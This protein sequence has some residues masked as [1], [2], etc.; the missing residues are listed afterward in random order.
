[1]LI[2]STAASLVPA[3][4]RAAASSSDRGDTQTVEN[5]SSESPAEA[6][7]RE[8]YAAGTR[9]F[10]IKFSDADAD[11]RQREQT[12]EK[13]LSNTGRI[14]TLFDQ[15]P[16]AIVS[17]FTLEGVDNALSR[18]GPDGYSIHA[19]LTLRTALSESLTFINQPAVVAAGGS[20]SGSVVAILDTG[21][22]Y[23]LAAFGSCSAPG[24]SCVVLDSVEIAQDDHQLDD[25][26]D[27]IFGHGTNVSAI[28]AGVAP[29]TQL[30]V[31]DVFNGTTASTVDLLTAVNQIVGRKA[32]G[33]NVVAVN[34]SLGISAYAP[35]ACPPDTIGMSSLVG[36]GI[37]PVVASGNMSLSGATSWPGCLTDVVQVGNIDDATAAIAASGNRSSDLE[38]VAPGVSIT[39]GGWTKTGTSMSSPHVAGAVAIL[40]SHRKG[41]SVE[42]TR[43]ALLA[44]TT[45]VADGS[46]TYPVLD[47]QASFDAIE[48]VAIPSVFDGA[49][50]SFFE[51]DAPSINS[52][53][54]GDIPVRA[55]Y[56]GDGDADIAVWRPSTGTWYIR[57]ASNVTYGAAGDIPIPADYDGDGDAD[58]AVAR[59]SGGVTTWYINGGSTVTFGAQTDIP[60]PADYDGDGDADIAVWRPST[61][62][63]YVRGE[64]PLLHWARERCSGDVRPGY[65]RPNT[66]ELAPPSRGLRTG[67][68]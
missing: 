60:V 20:G 50:G 46:A 52:G 19:P 66:P 9:E 65:L 26:S 42:A 62:T 2:M 11:I 31:F 37:V 21:V 61:G 64:D 18:R 67:T 63:W 30:V 34:I 48:D 5:T 53:T 36:A 39:A 3:T 32:A 49:T 12:L 14:V 54:S 15:I 51:G 44:T 40:R 4:Q 35:G 33:E 55:D 25:V 13:S 1:M 6:E 28:V 47:I 45:T 57:G 22:D 17:F 58:I 16:Y 68:G 38:I 41:L 10:I 29:Q 24:P 23:T 43:D 56:D 27:P 8:A 7:V 59:Q